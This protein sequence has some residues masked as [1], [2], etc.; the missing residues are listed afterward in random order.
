MAI[1]PTSV[2]CLTMHDPVNLCHG[3]KLIPTKTIRQP[4]GSALEPHAT[5]NCCRWNKQT[6]YV[7]SHMHTLDDSFQYTTENSML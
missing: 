2:P 6:Q 5:A 3:N 1:D 7:D 4:M